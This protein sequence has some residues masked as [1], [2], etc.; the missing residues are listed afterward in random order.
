MISV[1]GDKD[2]AQIHAI[3]ANT[4][5]FNQEEMECV[6]E[7]WEEYLA[8]GSECS[9][10]YFLVEKEAER[11]LGYACYGPRSLTSGTYD[12]YWI[13]VDPTVRRGGVGR[14]LLA[15]SEEAV[16]KLGGRLLVL[17]TSGLPTYEPTRKFY[18]TTGYT[19]EA[20]LKDFYSDGDD[21]VIFTKHL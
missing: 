15:A 12:L 1:P 20:T 10:Y 2:G 11:V 13:A 17:E 21:L 16:R 3:T 18:L 19:L 6:D 8:Q 4:T 5:V 7:L 9:G 14:G